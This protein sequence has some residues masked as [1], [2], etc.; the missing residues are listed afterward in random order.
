MA[1]SSKK[2]ATEGEADAAVIKATKPLTEGNK[3]PEDDSETKVYLKKQK[4][5]VKKSE[6]ETMEGFA[7]R[8]QR[9]EAKWINWKQRWICWQQRRI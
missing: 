8:L 1:G 7:D 9:L 2:S 4:K 5:D 3:Q 6:K